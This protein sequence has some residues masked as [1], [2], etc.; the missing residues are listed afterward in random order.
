MVTQEVA[1][2]IKD[3]ALPFEYHAQV[4]GEHIERKD[5]L[6][7]LYSYLAAAAI[8]IFLLLQAVLGSWRLAALSVVGM[9]VALLG[10]LVAT[11]IAS[12]AFSSAHCGFVT[13]LGLGV[14]TA[15]CW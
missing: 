15:S 3:I 6:S 9:P 5:S 1:R 4:L 11:T 2:R 10:S 8:M 12:D 7:S 13:V 14:R